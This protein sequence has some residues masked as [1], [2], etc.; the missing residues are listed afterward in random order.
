MSL[1][2]IIDVYKSAFGKEPAYVSMAPGRI[3]FLGNH[4]DYNGGC[5]MG[6]TLNMGV[7]AAISERD[8]TKIRLT[9]ASH[10]NTPIVE[11]SLDNL[12]PFGAG[13][14]SWANYPLGV[15]K[16]LIDEGAKAERGFDIAFWSDLPSGAGL[17][18]S[19]A[20]ELA[21]AKVMSIFYEKEIND[22]V[23]LARIGR[24]AENT[25]V[26]LP[27]GILDQGTSAHG[28][29]DH[30]VFIDCREE[31][32]HTYPLSEGTSFWVFNTHKKHSLVDSLY[33]QRHDECMQ[34]RD[35][36]QKT[37]N[38]IEHLCDLT[39]PQVEACELDL[40]AAS[41]KRAIHVTNENERVKRAAALL[42]S[43]KSHAVGELMFQSHESSKTLFENS[44]PELDFLVDALKGKDGV[45]GARL[46]GGGFGGAVVA[47]ADHTFTE[48]TAQ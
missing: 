7:Y 24:L 2:H 41:F 8:D 12:V 33:A 48:V 27:C 47:W 17:S 22:P 16:V 32:F 28:R 40:P 3:E 38:N 45:L 30:L 14:N 5:V 15:L 43:G 10:G 39:A 4:T 37:Y 19:A 13:R 11:A 44:I 21:S 29:K 36:L 31:S 9:S 23:H 35:T 6:A 20:I 25:F 1:N 26:G 34:A 46:T 42:A 18:S